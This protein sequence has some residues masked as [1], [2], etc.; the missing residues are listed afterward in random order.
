MSMS[1]AARQTLPSAREVDVFR[2]C[3]HGLP[4][5]EIG[6]QLGVTVG[7]IKGDP[8]HVDRKLN[9][10]KHLGTIAKV[11]SRGH[12]QDSVQTLS[13]PKT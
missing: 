7:T 6:D 3:S 13:L 11:R 12:L 5:Q 9:L 8:V 10:R 4:G 2:R 1:D